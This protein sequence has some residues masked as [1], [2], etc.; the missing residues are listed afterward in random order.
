MCWG[1]CAVVSNTPPRSGARSSAFFSVV[2]RHSSAE[3]EVTSTALLE[4]TPEQVQRLECAA[5]FVL[6]ARGRIARFLTYLAPLDV[7]DHV[8]QADRLVFVRAV[9]PI[10]RPSECHIPPT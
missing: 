10:S 7:Y 3:L 6:G 1:M 5:A 9:S 2:S 8:Q 4:L